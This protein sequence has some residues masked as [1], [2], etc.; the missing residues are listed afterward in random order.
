MHPSYLHQQKMMII[1]MTVLKKLK[2]MKVVVTELEGFKRISGYED[3]F[4]LELSDHFLALKI[5][6]LSSVTLMVNPKSTI[7]I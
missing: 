7:K 4:L 2:Q 1:M 6:C 3:I 5:C